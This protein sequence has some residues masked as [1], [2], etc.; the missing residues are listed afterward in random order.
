MKRILL[1]EMTNVN[2]LLY[3]QGN[4]FSGVSYE[5]FDDETVRA[6]LVHDGRL[7]KPYLSPYF[8]DRSDLLHVDLSAGMSDYEIPCFDGKPYSGIAYSFEKDYCEREALLIEGDVISDTWWSN[9]GI[10]LRYEQYTPDYS[11]IYEWY[12]DGALKRCSIWRR[13][14]FNGALTYS[15]DG[16]LKGIGSRRGFFGEFSRI[17]SKSP[18]FPVRNVSDL[19]T[20]QCAE[21]VWLV[22]EDIDDFFVGN[23]CEAGML[24]QTKK[25]CIVDT[26]ITD[27]GITLLAKCP[28]LR[29]FDIQEKDVHR[30]QLLKAALAGMESIQAKFS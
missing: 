10:L 13:D 14:S 16:H 27:S 20:L 30:L 29:N 18:A 9:D 6:W 3:Y 26:S 8:D 1:S 4:L 21:E 24:M 25:I 7:D 5:R 17:A 22:G 2:G 15:Q 28:L 11:E 12:R 19:F 23:M